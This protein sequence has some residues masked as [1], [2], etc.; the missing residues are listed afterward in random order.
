[1]SSIVRVLY[2]I[3]MPSPD[4]GLYSIPQYDYAMPRLIEGRLPRDA[5]S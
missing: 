1:M 3:L 5:R 2:Y 4:L